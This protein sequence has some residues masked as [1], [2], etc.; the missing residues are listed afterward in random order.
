MTIEQAVDRI[1]GDLYDVQQKPKPKAGAKEWNDGA[2]AK[3]SGR[4]AGEEAKPGREKA[5][6]SVRQKLAEMEP[7]V[8]DESDM[9]GFLP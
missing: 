6:D 5:L 8:P 1:V 4:R 9:D 3:P 2:V 7:G